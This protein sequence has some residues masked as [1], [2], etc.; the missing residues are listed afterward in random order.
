MNT[1]YENQERRHHEDECC[2]HEEAPAEITLNA[3]AAG[4]LQTTLRVAGVDCA[5]EV[6]LIQRALQPLGGC[7][8]CE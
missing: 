6:S 3:S 8:K 2:A 1:S 4:N 5:E 7:V